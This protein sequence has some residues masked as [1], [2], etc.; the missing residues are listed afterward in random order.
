MKIINRMK[1]TMSGLRRI[2]RETLEQD[3]ED[4]IEDLMSQP[5]YS[6]AESLVEYKYD[7]EETEYNFAELQAVARNMTKQKLGKKLGSQVVTAGASELNLVKKTM[8]SFGIKF[9]GRQPVKTIRGVTSS[10]HG[11]NPFAGNAG[12]SGMGWGAD[13]PVGFGMGGGVGAMGGGKPWSASD[14]K[15]LPMGSRRR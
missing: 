14:T 1:I 4:Q 9:V 2:I 8:D 15:N 10:K 12:G 6:S 13:G 7:N 11:S 3:V 5:E